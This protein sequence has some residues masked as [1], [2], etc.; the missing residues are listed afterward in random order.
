MFDIEKARI[1]HYQLVK[2]DIRGEIKQRITQRDNFAIQFIITV[3]VILAASLT[4]NRLH[5][6]ILLPL[7]SLYYCI[8]ILYSYSIHAVLHKFLVEEIE[9]ALTKL[10][11]TN[12]LH[13]WEKYYKQQKNLRGKEYQPGIR[14]EFY[15]Y[16][17]WATILLVGP[18]LSVHYY[19][20]TLEFIGIKFWILSV[21]ASCIYTVAA[22]KIGRYYFKYEKTE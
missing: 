12:E 10:L 20:D 8:Q 7:A 22:Y 16:T 2:Q 9:P 3:G 11:V 14:K 19:N 4:N 5:I 6:L 18:L 17:N 13:E 21:I 1:E 15:Y